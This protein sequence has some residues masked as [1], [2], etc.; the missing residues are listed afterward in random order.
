MTA[1]FPNIPLCM[2]A[3]YQ[4]SMAKTSEGGGSIRSKLIANV[5]SLIT[6]ITDLDGKVWTLREFITAQEEPQS[7][8]PYVASV[9][10]IPTQGNKKSVFTL[11]TTYRSGNKERT[12]QIAEKA[13]KFVDEQLAA[14]V[15]RKFGMNETEKVLAPA[16][17][18]RIALRNSVDLTDIPALSTLFSEAP[19]NESDNEPADGRG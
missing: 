12:K 5:D 13:T 4:H 6:P 7:G 17:C 9:C 16:I 15:W 19:E 1:K 18:Q 14:L 8:R 11:F 3:D 2:L 10:P